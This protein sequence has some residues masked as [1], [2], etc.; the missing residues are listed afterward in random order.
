MATPSYRERM[1][2]ARAAARAKRLAEEAARQRNSPPLGGNGSVVYF[3]GSWGW[4]GRRRKSSC[5][6]RRAEVMRELAAQFLTLAE[7]QRATAPLM[8]GHRLMPFP[9]FAQVTWRKVERIATAPSRSTIPPRIVR[10]R[11]GL[12]KMLVYQ[13]CLIGGWPCSCLATPR[14]RSWTP[15]ARSRMLARSAKLL[16]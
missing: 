12:A 14:P 4:H 3:A 5:A 10:W 2:A 7:K 16:V 11:R 9:C 15:S 8:I 13:S 1:K 6:K